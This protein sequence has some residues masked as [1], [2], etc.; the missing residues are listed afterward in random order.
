MVS[1]HIT[2]DKQPLFMSFWIHLL[3]KSQYFFTKSLQKVK[4]GL[5]LHAQTTRLCTHQRSVFTFIFT[6]PNKQSGMSYI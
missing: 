6:L 3:A 1:F 5:L 2:Q 4:K